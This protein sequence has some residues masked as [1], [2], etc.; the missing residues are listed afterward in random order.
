MVR[1]KFKY[2]VQTHVNNEL[3]RL[4]PAASEAS[5]LQRPSLSQVCNRYLQPLHGTLKIG[6]NSLQFYCTSSSGNVT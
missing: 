6:T 5:K 3:L 4:K 1:Y 2:T